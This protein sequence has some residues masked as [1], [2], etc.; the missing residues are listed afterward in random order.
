MDLIY[1]NKNKIDVGVLKDYSFDLA[2]GSDENNFKLSVNTENNVCEEDYIIY[3]EG[4]EYGG[5]AD[6]IEGY[7]DQKTVNYKGRTWHGILNTKIVV[8]DNGQDYY[9]VSGDANTVLGTLISRL[10]L[11]GLFKA[12]TAPSGFTLSSYQFK[13]YVGGYDGIS[14][15]LK[16][17]GAKLHIEWLN[18]FAVLSAIA[19]GQYTDE[20]IDSDHVAI[21][22]QKTYNPVN[23]LICLGKGDLA[24]RTVVNLYSDANGNI[25]TTQTFTGVEEVASVYDYPNVESAEDLQ[26]EGIKKLKELYGADLVEVSLDNTYEFDIGDILTVEEITTGIKVSRR[27]IKKIVTISNE[28]FLVNYKIGE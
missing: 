10:S 1:A 28:Q 3:I 25:S 24:A 9:I 8:P 15:M 5:I 18:G 4:T 2:F 21:H 27:V 7:S 17:V 14:D 19:I 26:R 22:I 23:H 6:S 12:S 11:T 16:S 13:R 20:E